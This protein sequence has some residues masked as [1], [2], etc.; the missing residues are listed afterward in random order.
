MIELHI[1]GEAGVKN[2]YKIG[3]IDAVD[4]VVCDTLSKVLCRELFGS[5]V[6]LAI[7]ELYAG[8]S[9]TIARM[10]LADFSVDEVRLHAISSAYSTS[11]STRMY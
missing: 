11:S 6:G 3:G 2:Q 7:K 8:S 10:E 9:T 4:G 5:S 1:K